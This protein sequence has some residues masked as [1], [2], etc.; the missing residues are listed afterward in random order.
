MVPSMSDLSH[1]VPDFGIVSIKDRKGIWLIHTLISS[2][3]TFQ[4][5]DEDLIA[6]LHIT[7]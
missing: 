5:V 2:Y 6:S 4:Q 7:Y 3:I 1:S